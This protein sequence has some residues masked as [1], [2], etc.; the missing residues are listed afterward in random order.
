MKA[1]N[2]TKPEF[3]I[4]SRGRREA[5]SEGEAIPGLQAK[6][7]IAS[8]QELLAMANLKA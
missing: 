8:S 3:V 7:W 5:P 2:K 6:I 1:I 4:A